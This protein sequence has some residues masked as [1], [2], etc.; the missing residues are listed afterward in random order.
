MS[1]LRLSTLI[2]IAAPLVAQEKELTSGRPITPEQA[3]FDVTRYA[4]DVRVDPQ[5]HS[6]TG[7]VQ[8]DA[9]LLEETD[10]LVLDLDDRLEVEKVWLQVDPEPEKLAFKH[11]QG[12]LK[13]NVKGKLPP[14]GDDFALVVE[15]GGEPRVAPRAPWDGGFVWETTPS[16]QPWIATANQMQGADLWWPVKDQPDDEPA[17]MDIRVTVP[18]PLICASNGKLMSVTD[19]EEDG[20]HTFHWH[21]ST[22][23]NHYGVALNI[24]PYE[25]IV[26]EYTSTAGDTFEVTYW[27][28]PENVEKGKVLMDDILRQMRFME[29]TY[30]PYPFRGD[31]YGVAETPHLGMEHQSIIAYGNNYRGNP[32]GTQRGFDFLHLHEFAHEWWANLVTARNWNDF[33]IHE[34][35]ATYAEALYVEHLHGEEAYHEQ[36]GEKRGGI[37]NAGAVAPRDPMSTAD[38]YFGDRPG[39]PGGDIYSKGAWILHTLR[40]VVGDEAFF[41]ILRRMAYPDPDLEDLTDGSA[42]HF[43]TTDEFQAIAEEISGQDLGWL[44]EVYLRQPKLPKLETRQKGDKLYLEWDV[45]DDLPF[46]MPVQVQAGDLILRVDVPAGG[47]ETELFD[48]EYVQVDPRMWILKEEK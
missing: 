4:I 34:G 18:K 43:A 23:I 38:M 45:P 9:R 13:L 6:I 26:R 29:E 16:G 25:T 42:C 11:K 5:S 46:P 47:G 31:K 33:W 44:F 1:A 12:E 20:W 37:L 14:V 36:M 7:T 24:A 39:S 10:A 19:A 48:A 17:T 35:F 2:L 27:V 8:V 30:G 15:Y 40:W 22:P 3:C 32:W 21:V 41:P 28:L